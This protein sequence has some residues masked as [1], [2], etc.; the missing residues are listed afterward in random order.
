MYEVIK[1]AQFAHWI[2]ALRDLQARARILVR[3]ERLRNGNAGDVRPVGQGVSELRIDTGP[4]YRVYYLQHG[5]RLILLLC[6]G[7]KRT[8]A[9]DIRKAHELA[10]QF[11]EVQ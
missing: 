11:Q 9:D 2:D 3:I 6:G 10:A 1:T 5:S 8:Q 4:G 7:S